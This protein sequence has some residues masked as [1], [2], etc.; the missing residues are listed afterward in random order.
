M[1]GGHILGGLLV[2]IVLCR[3]NL[4]CAFLC[5]NHELTSRE[6]GIE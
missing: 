4:K 5:H 6:E 2:P 1:L 3:F